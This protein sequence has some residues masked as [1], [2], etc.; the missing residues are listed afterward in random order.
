VQVKPPLVH[1]DPADPE[2]ERRWS[3]I[4]SELCPAPPARAGFIICQPGMLEKL[5]AEDLKTAG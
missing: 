2:A 3:E 4:V 1:I 5:K